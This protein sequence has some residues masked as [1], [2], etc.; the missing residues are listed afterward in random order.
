MDANA[1]ACE[2]ND[3]C[4]LQVK[5]EVENNCDLGGLRLVA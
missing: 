5:L 4:L 3:T 2:D 1:D